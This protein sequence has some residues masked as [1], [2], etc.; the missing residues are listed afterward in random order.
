MSQIDSELNSLRMRIAVLEEQKRIESE[1]ASEKTA[2][3]L[4][5]LE[6]IINTKKIEIEDD[7]K[8]PRK[9]IPLV[10]FYEKENVAFLEPIINALKNIQE[11]LE[12]LEKKE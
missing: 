1:I 4:N 7:R 10:K 12:I 9:R 6:V 11:R 3:P 8:H 2:F 5:V